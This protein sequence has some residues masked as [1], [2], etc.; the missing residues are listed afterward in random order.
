M[1]PSARTRDRSPDV[2]RSTPAL[3]QP[4]KNAAPEPTKVTPWRAAKRHSVPQSGASRG[5][6]GLPSKMTQVVPDSR[7][8]TWQFHIT[9]PVELYQ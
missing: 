3:A 1:L 4:A 8:A 9:Q 2:A 5:P 7:P 6:P